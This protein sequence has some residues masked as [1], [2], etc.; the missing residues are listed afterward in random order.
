[1]G[2]D[3]HREGRFKERVWTIRQRR[4]GTRPKARSTSPHA[5]V[6]GR[7]L[8]GCVN[9]SA[10]AFQRMLGRKN[11]GVGSALALRAFCDARDSGHGLEGF[12]HRFEI[13]PAYQ[14]SGY[15]SSL[16]FIA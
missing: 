11:A 7:R 14:G 15:C 9:L 5:A 16:A 13:W 1:M 2:S 12:E 8:E 4:S 10:W 3:K 6:V